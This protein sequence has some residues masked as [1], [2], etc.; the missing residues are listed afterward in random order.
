M[1]LNTKLDF[2]D[3]SVGGTIPKQFIPIIMKEF[4]KIAE[5]GGKFERN[6]TKG[7]M[8]LNSF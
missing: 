5:R 3:E 7:K 1:E 6:T 2:V 8:I 4:L